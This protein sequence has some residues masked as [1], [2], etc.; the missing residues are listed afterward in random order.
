[1]IFA[2]HAAALGIG[3]PSLNSVPSQPLLMDRD[4]GHVP[5]DDAANSAHREEYHQ[6]QAVTRPTVNPAAEQPSR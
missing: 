1:M 2:S 3:M 6:L 5:Q 4:R